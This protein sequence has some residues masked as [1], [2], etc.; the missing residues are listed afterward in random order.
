MRGQA[1]VEY[2][3]TYGWA[4]LALVIILGV[5][6]FSGI[7]S[8]NYLISEECNF[9]TNLPCQFAL[10]NSGGKT[11][12]TMRIH[13]GFQYKINVTELEVYKSNDPSKKFTIPG[14]FIK[15]GGNETFSTELDTLL[16]PNSIGRYLV[17]LS[18]VSC[19]PE[20]T[21]EGEECGNSKHTIIGKVTGRV[22]SD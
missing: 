5:L 19:A 18:Y 9:G 6:I 3:M 16:A 15:S 21:P 1:A 22:I 13:N 8:P 2:L 12:L 14:G 10:F 20:V 4:I 11:T 7:L 17:N